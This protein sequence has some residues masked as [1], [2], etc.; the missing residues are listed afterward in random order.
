MIEEMR[1][2]LIAWE[3]RS[4]D[5]KHISEI[6]MRLNIRDWQKMEKD[7]VKKWFDAFFIFKNVD[8]PTEAL[9]ST[10]KGWDDI[11][12]DKSEPHSLN[13]HPERSDDGY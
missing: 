4:F 9:P 2:A 1:D 5:L 11:L 8:R 10:P 13:P 6:K 12:K 3:K 7:L